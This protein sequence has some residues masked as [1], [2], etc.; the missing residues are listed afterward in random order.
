MDI[1]TLKNN[2]IFYEGYEGEPEIVLSATENKDCNIHL[3]E[4]YFDDIFSDPSLDGNGWKG[5][6][7]DIHQME[8]IFND[9][10][11]SA[12]IDA[13]EYLEDLLTYTNRNFDYDES[14]DAL[15]LLVEF[16]KFAIQN[17]YTVSAMKK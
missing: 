8:G 7:R 3:W 1:G 11:A 12:N 5:F 6:T 15:A 16:L 17:N 9:D 4:G 14:A 2:T 13:Q 10:I